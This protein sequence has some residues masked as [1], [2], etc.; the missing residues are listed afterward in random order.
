[1]RA[2]VSSKLDDIESYGSTFDEDERKA[3]AAADAAIEV[4]I[5]LHHRQNS[6]QSDHGSE[7]SVDGQ[8]CR[9]D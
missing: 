7:G 9:D 3:L 4:A 1:M 8:A 2:V 6:R 5:L